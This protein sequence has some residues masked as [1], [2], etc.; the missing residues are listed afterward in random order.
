MD[1][2]IDGEPYEQSRW[3]LV[4]GTLIKGLL[5][6]TYDIEISKDGYRNWKNEIPVEPKLVSEL[7]NVILLPKEIGAETVASSTADFFVASGRIITLGKDLNFEGNILPGK[8]FTG[9][10]GSADKIVTYDPKQKTYLLSDLKEKSTLN[11]SLLFSNL[12]KRSKEIKDQT[13]IIKMK[14]AGLNSSPEVF[15]S[16]GEAFYAMNPGKLELLEV[17]EK[18]WPIMEINQRGNL[19]FA[20]NGGEIA[21]FNSDTK[22][23]ALTKSVIGE[24][25]KEIK[26]NELSNAG[27][28]MKSGKLFYLKGGEMKI[29]AEEVRK[30]AL[31]QK[32]RVAFIDGSGKIK[33][34]DTDRNS[35]IDTEAQSPAAIEGL[36]FLEEDH[37]IAIY[38]DA[39]YLSEIAGRNLKL[40][41]YSLYFEKIAEAARIEKFHLDREKKDIYYLDG[42]KNLKIINYFEGI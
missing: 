28:L 13:A 22:E 16:T 40:D 36:V 29:I 2:K 24:E 32:E 4:S 33:I 15:I 20:A 14:T 12:R 1:I 18:P 30:F 11:L 21:V 41:N 42:E 27:I 26:T 39:I 9:F 3:L 25:V 35:I 34:S 38:P 23:K 37:L 7:N 10:M 6:K 5:P 17:D 8:E 31:S 19:M